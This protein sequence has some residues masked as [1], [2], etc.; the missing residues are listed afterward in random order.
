MD[1]DTKK[2]DQGSSPAA[3]SPA[4]P[5]AQDSVE[6]ASAAP[7]EPSPAAAIEMMKGYID[8][9]TDKL[10][11]V[12]AEMDNFRKRSERE[13]KEMAEYAIV[14]FARDVVTVADN[15]ERAVQALPQG[16]VEQNT[17]LKSLVEG[18]AMTE[19][20]FVNVLE[21]YGVKRISPKGERFSA[22]QHQAITELPNLA[23][24]P[25]TILE[26][27]QPGY[28]IDDHVLRPAK[29]VVATG[30]EKPD[31]P[32]EPPPDPAPDSGEEQSNV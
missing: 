28:L 31:K 17:A 18:V 27:L 4:E 15:I 21:R 19:R 20:E 2:T 25:G 10:L 14:R 23:V 16:A 30:R 6:Q 22:K 29:V 8:D 13:N 7:A 3:G 5:V 32:G 11:R 9:L 26:V 12:H 24:R 1:D